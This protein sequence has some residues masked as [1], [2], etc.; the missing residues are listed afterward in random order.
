ME[1]TTEH[2]DTAQSEVPAPTAIPARDRRNYLAFG[3]EPNS[4]PYRLRLARYAALAETIAEFVKARPRTAE[5]V[6][7]LD[8]GAGDGRTYRY[9][10]PHGVTDAV[11][12]H[13]VE[14]DPK[15][16][17]GMYARD[18][19][20]QVHHRDLTDGLPYGDEQFDIVVCEQVLEHLDDPASVIDE[21]ARV[22]K[23]GGLLV[24][25]VPTFPPI[26]AQIRRHIVPRLDAR[27]GIDRGHV[28]VFCAR[29]LRRLIRE[30]MPGVRVRTRGFRIVSGGLFTRLE[31]THGWYRLNRVVG[32]LLPWMCVENQALAVKASA[33]P[34]PATSAARSASAVVFALASMEVAYE[35][36]TSK[37]GVRRGGPQ[38]IARP[39]GPGPDPRAGHSLRSTKP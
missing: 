24:I 19:W 12:F 28:Q 29:S 1:S 11:E 15:R 16:I 13:A 26:L 6:R 36:W 20:A 9:L 25:G 2:A 3:V 7:L 33:R 34:R 32:G 10:E 35:V 27:K 23:P 5:P 22:L 14:L 18:R 21:L 37:G 39:I 38:A 17:E 30:R 31:H 8:A 4:R